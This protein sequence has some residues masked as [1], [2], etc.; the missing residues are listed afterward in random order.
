M[1]LLGPALLQGDR[2]SKSQ[3]GGVPK[4]GWTQ[5]AGP[6][7]K[8]PISED[9]FPKH[10]LGRRVYQVWDWSQWAFTSRSLALSI[11]RQRYLTPVPTSPSCERWHGVGQT[12]RGVPGLRA[13]PSWS[14]E[15]SVTSPGRPARPLDC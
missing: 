3:P 12:Q 7:A 2:L 1:N 13:A 10:R 14:L 6:T 9:M 11:R 15:A 5:F 8:S 4:L